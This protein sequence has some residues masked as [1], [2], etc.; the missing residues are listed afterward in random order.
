MSVVIANELVDFKNK[1]RGKIFNM[2][3]T[4]NELS[5][6]LVSLKNWCTTTSSSISSVYNSSNKNTLLEKFL[7]INTVYD[8]IDNC[9]SNDVNDILVKATK[10][11]NNIDEL[12]NKVIELNNLYSKMNNKDDSN[13]SIYSSRYYSLKG[14]FDKLHSESLTILNEL[15]ANDEK[16]SFQEEFKVDSIKDVSNYLAY[17][18]FTKKV[19]KSSN[20]SKTEYYLYVP[21]VSDTTGLPMMVYMHGSGE[22]GNGVLNQGLPKQIYEKS[23]VPNGLVICVQCPAESGFGVSQMQSNIIEL[24]NDVADEYKVDKKR[25]SASGHSDGAISGYKLVANNPNLFS[26]FV[27]ISGYGL[28]A[29]QEKIAKDGTKVWAFHGKN[30]VSVEY[31]EGKNTVNGIKNS[32]GDAELYTLDDGHRIQTKIFGTMYNYKGEAIDP[33]ERAFNQSRS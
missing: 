7:N 27:P 3:S 10:L 5:S 13:Y 25:I 28:Q 15:K 31:S 19:F 26:A 20:G 11:L 2:Q 6:K 1:V 14:E 24:I 30:D 21:D 18:T 4:L 16:I 17:G 33:L 32:G 29:Y 12:E 22:R 9:I 23:V 8:K